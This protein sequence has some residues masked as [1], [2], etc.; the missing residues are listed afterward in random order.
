LDDHFAGYQRDDSSKRVAEGLVKSV[1]LLDEIKT[2][3]FHGADLIH[4]V[5]V[6]VSSKTK[7]VDAEHS[8]LS[9]F[10]SLKGE[11]KR[12]LRSFIL[13]VGQQEDR[14]HFVWNLSISNGLQ[15]KVEAAH[16]A[17]AS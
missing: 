4:Q 14:S 3:I 1:E 17:R 8:E 13:T 5:L 2:S 6:M 7:T 9:V 12:F 16:N 15:S 11:S 10:R